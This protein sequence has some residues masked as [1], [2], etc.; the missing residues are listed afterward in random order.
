MRLGLIGHGAIAETVLDGLAAGDGGRLARLVCL[1]RPEAQARA[2]AF[3]ARHPDAAGECSVVTTLDAFL[4]AD[5]ALAV[6]CAGQDALRTHGERVLS[7]G[8]DLVAASV[9]ALA[10]DDLHRRLVRAAERSGARLLLPPGAIGGLDILGAARLAGIEEIVY[11]SRKPPTAWRE[12]DA[13][14]LVDLA[15]LTAAA[16]FYDGTARA[17]AR[18]YPKNANV[19]ASVAI[20]GLGFD[21]TR[22]QLIADPAVSRNVHEITLRSA[23]ADMRIRIE[24]RA[25]PRNP[26][27][28]LTTGYSIAR[29]VLD[30]MAHEVI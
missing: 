12:T 28:S 24:G 30:Q 18:D 16:T 27:T 11:V 20:A 29:L 6:E 7:A 14:R 13:E 4:A 21:R 10:D 23:C 1:A 3:L 26:K 2:E 25:S 19:A 8:I 9:G 5:L 22:V 15:G 17:A